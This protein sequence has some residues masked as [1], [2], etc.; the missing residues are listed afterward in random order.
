MSVVVEIDEVVEKLTAAKVTGKEIAVIVNP[1]T[2]VTT[3][4]VLQDF[5][6]YYTT[7]KI[8]T[9]QLSNSNNRREAWLKLYN[10]KENALYEYTKEMGGSSKISRGV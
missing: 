8:Y 7:T 5:A 2:S 10:Q 4:K 1:S 6:D 3:K 9:T